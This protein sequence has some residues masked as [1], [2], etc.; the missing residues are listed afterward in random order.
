MTD[1]S[2]PSPAPKRRRKAAGALGPWP[3]S[4]GMRV[5]EKYGIS[6]LALIALAWFTATYMI[7]PLVDSARAS[8]ESVAEKVGEIE[9]IFRESE[10]LE[11]EQSARS[12]AAIE[13]IK[14]E[15]SIHRQQAAELRDTM[16]GKFLD[17]QAKEFRGH[18]ATMER[19]LRDA[20][21]GERDQCDFPSGSVRGIAVGP[22]PQSAPVV[23][24]DKKGDG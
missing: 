4:M 16:L 5:L 24:V 17:A 6:T 3:V 10:K 23:P 20:I 15:I 1:E 18:E 21:R 13:A 2:T 14:T 7:R 11:R 19:I 9:V 22:E 8:M 12:T